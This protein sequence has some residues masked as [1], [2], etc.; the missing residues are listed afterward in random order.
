MADKSEEEKNKA[1]EANIEIWKIK[2]L[3]K[4]LEEARGCVPSPCLPVPSAAIM[5]PRRCSRPSALAMACV[6]GTAR[7]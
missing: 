1:A 3:I 7:A 5:A 6:A 2:K 4:K